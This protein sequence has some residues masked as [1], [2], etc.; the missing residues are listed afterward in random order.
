MKQYSPPKFLFFLLILVFLAGISGCKAAPGAPSQ[1]MATPE[2]L[3]IAGLETRLVLL[4]EKPAVGRPIRVRVELANRGPETWVFNEGHRHISLEDCLDV[5]G[6]DEIEVPY[7]GGF[8]QGS[9]TVG[10]LDPGETVTLGMELDI[11]S[12]HPIIV[13]GRYRVRFGGRRLKMCLLKEAP[14]VFVINANASGA[15]FGGPG[16]ESMRTLLNSP[17][18]LPSEWINIEIGPGTPAPEMVIATRLLKV[19]PEG[20]K[21]KINPRNGPSSVT[22]YI[23]RPASRN[24]K[25]IGMGLVFRQKEPEGKW[26]PLGHS[27]MGIVYHWMDEEA[28]EVWEQHRAGIKEALGIVK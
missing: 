1:R 17:V 3:Q 23:Y 12:L 19:L 11:A 5:I 28:S 15:L 20:W 21:L 16:W 6:P 7:V 22:A 14:D 25:M 2:I 9:H 10:T 24:T 8:V 13:P 27:P 18:R 26:K 4:D